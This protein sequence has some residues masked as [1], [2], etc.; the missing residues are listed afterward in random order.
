MK[1][2]EILL[3]AF[4][5]IPSLVSGIV[6]GL[7]AG[8]LQKRP[9]EA[10]NSIAW[11]LWHLARVEDDHL[12]DAAGTQQLW[13]SDGWAERFDL[14]FAEDDTG[15]GFSSE[16]V[17]KVKVS[18]PELLT[19]YYDAVHE[20]TVNYVGGLTDD[21]LNRIVDDSWDPPVTLGARLVSVTQ[22]CLQHAGQAAYVKGLLRQE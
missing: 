17:S 5:R 16:Q 14:P 18:S 19:Q 4:G 1:S 8:D 11:L 6:D 20:R 10:G 22:D 12:A 21:D 9:A 13:S 7:S 3:E 15:Y 2:S